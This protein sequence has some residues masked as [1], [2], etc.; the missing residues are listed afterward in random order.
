MRQQICRGCGQAEI[1]RLAASN[2]AKNREAIVNLS[3][4]LFVMSPYTSLLVLENDDMIAQYRV[5][6]GRKDHWAKY[7][8]PERIEIVV[9]P[10]P[11]QPDPR[12]AGK[13]QPA[14]VVAKSVWCETFDSSGS[15]YSDQLTSA[16]FAG[17]S[18]DLRLSTNL[19][20]SPLDATAASGA[21]ALYAASEP[22]SPVGSDTS[23]SVASRRAN[24]LHATSCAAS[25]GRPSNARPRHW[26][27][28][29]NRRRLTPSDQQVGR[30]SHAFR[31]VAIKRRIRI[32]RDSDYD[33]GY[34]YRSWNEP[35]SAS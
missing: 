17:I 34:R 18:F 20:G 16:G 32:Q 7:A 2:P 9:E 19:A 27:A 6:G 12:L 14:K 28:W 23:T 31:F 4:S 8:A 10:E 15:R 29:R 24:I 3:R 1:D 26:E 21:F 11:G 22:T 5:D 30:W 35:Q 33:C 25:G 13:R